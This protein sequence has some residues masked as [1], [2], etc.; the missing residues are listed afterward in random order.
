MDETSPVFENFL[1]NMSRLSGGTRRVAASK[2]LQREDTPTVE[3]NARKIRIIARILK[4]RRVN[5]GQNIMDIKETMMSILG[6]LE[7][8]EK[9]EYEKFLDMQRRMENDKR[10]R[11]ESGLELD[12]KGLNFINRGVNK[13]LKPVKSIFSRVISGI[14]NLI[15][16][17]LL[18][19]LLNFFANPRNASL[20][21]FI[22]GFIETFFPVLLGGIA[23]AAI[24]LKT[25][26]GALTL[27]VNILKGLSVGL[28][29]TPAASG[30][31]AG[32]RDRG[33]TGRPFLISN[34]F[35][36]STFKNI[37]KRLRFNTG[38]IVPGSG[39]TDSVPAMLTPGE[40]VISK[41]AVQSIGAGRL[42]SLN[43]QFGGI[44]RPSLRGGIPYAKEGMEVKK[45]PKLDDFNAPTIE[46]T[47]NTVLENTPD[48]K[49]S[50]LNKNVGG[51][52]GFN[53]LAMSNT[54]QNILLDFIKNIFTPNFRPEKKEAV[55]NEN[56]KPNNKTNLQGSD[57]LTDI[58]DITNKLKNPDESL[59]IENDVINISLN[60]A[61][62]NKIET[63]GMVA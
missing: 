7:A 50:D 61:D 41:P 22:S 1:N 34:V 35:K 60:P 42:L 5:M 38:G 62:L 25:I 15:A 20:V 56:L 12:K 27:A 40:V 63:L 37:V 24:G 48:I 8:Q 21:K 19:K 14:F 18:I 30:V 43:R 4:A 17:R 54:N 44:G 23:V 6:T 13:V 59:E 2:F 11:R 53:K 29:V 39:N 55:N 49:S 26:S 9:F 57:G 33:A 3:G 46:M 31:T 51:V 16:G 32:L 58:N 52:K 10:K 45:T 47:M 28:G 36:G